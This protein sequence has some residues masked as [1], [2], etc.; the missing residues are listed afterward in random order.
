MRYRKSELSL[1]PMASQFC[2]QLLDLR[3]L[4][5]VISSQA[6]VFGEDIHCIKCLSPGMVYLTLPLA[7]GIRVPFPKLAMRLRLED[8]LGW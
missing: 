8:S 7:G 5:F 2:L 4:L 1:S 3:R 6:L